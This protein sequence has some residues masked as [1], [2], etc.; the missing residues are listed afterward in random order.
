MP[1][2]LHP[3]GAR[4]AHAV[5]ELVAPAVVGATDLD[6][7]LAARVGPRQP[8]RAHHRLSAGTEHPQHLHAGHELADQLGQLH[9]VLVQEAGDRP[10]LIQNLIHLAPQL[11]RIGAQQRRP[12]GL[13]KVGVAVAVHVGQVRAGGLRHRQ[14]EGIIEG[15]VV[16][17]TAGNDLLGSLREPLGALAAILEIAHDA[18][19]ALGLD[20][21][22]RLLDE[23]GEAPV[24]RIDVGPFGN[25]GLRRGRRGVRWGSVFQ[26]AICKGNGHCE[27]SSAAAVSRKAAASWGDAVRALILLCRYSRE[28]RSR[29]STA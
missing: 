27:L 21:P 19:H 28:R 18:R 1:D 5:D 11:R 12:A 25:R 15:Q 10:A 3:S 8:D 23:F 6:D 2:R 29:S 7:P 20:R 26:R 22:H 4:Q 16:L 14:R 13:Q 9:L 24:E 17:H